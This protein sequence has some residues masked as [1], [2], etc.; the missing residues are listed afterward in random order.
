MDEKKLTTIPMHAAQF[1]QLLLL[2]E[3]NRGKPFAVLFFAEEVE[4]HPETFY[5]L[6]MA[7]HKPPE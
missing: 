5:E 4:K 7:Q 3:K 1:A 2:A 6:F